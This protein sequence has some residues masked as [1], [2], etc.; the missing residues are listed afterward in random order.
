MRAE[1]FRTCNA[2]NYSK[3]KSIHDFIAV[4]PDDKVIVVEMESISR[5]KSRVDSLR[6]KY[7]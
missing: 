5:C 4:S 1:G 3:H 6:K 2:S 7:T